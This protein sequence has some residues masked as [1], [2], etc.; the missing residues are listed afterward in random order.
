MIK[1]K[2][3]NCLSILE[4]VKKELNI[5]YYIC[6]AVCL[7]YYNLFRAMAGSFFTISYMR[8]FSGFN[9]IIPEADIFSK[10]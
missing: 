4:I 9:L 5:K 2:L 10:N 8:V 6:P 7:N 1:F 3:E